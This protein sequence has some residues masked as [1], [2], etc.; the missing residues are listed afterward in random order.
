MK[1]SGGPAGW[2]QKRHRLRAFLRAHYET[3]S[4]EELHALGFSS[5]S[6]SDLVH[7][8]RLLVRYCYG[9]YRSATAPESL[10]GSL[11]A[12]LL[13]AKHPRS[14]LDRLSAAHHLG[15]AAW[16]P[17]K[18]Q[19]VIPRE[20]GYRK[21]PAVERRADPRLVEA[22]VFAPRGL[23]CLR[24]QRLIVRLA[25][26]AAGRDADVRDLRVFKRVVRA[27]AK[28]DDRLVPRWRAA[29]EAGSFAGS[30]VLAA[31]LF[32]GFE[33]TLD[34]RS[35]GE[36]ELVDLCVRFGLPIPQTNVWVHGFEVD[37]YWEA[38]GVFA[39]VSPF[40]THGDEVSV[41]RDQQRISVLS[42]FGLRAFPVSTRRMRSEPAV[43]AAS[44]GAALAAR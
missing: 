2:R 16:A 42:G 8:E 4:T 5:S 23:R 43:V 28:D 40:E 14:T 29:L 17:P 30:S 22:D 36:V 26:A 25:A 6:I 12:E 13:R 11:R 41:E 37:G 15:Y 1:Y 35:D 39:E 34:V 33:R 9:V 21:D 10:E 19:L 27:A 44:L 24:P 38:H 31:E 7:V 32:P 18:P 20:S 3:V